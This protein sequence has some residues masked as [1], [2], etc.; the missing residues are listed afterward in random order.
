LARRQPR[1]HHRL[2][3]L[4]LATLK[5]ATPLVD[6]RS[7]TALKMGNVVVAGDGTSGSTGWTAEIKVDALE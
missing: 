4:A 1:P 5:S 6:G 3:Q 2:G 7:Y